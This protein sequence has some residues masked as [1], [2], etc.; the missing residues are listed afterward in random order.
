MHKLAEGGK[1]D[2]L[3]FM[4]ITFVLDCQE[5]KMKNNF[6]EFK[7]YFDLM[8]KFKPVYRDA[9]QKLEALQ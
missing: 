1:I 3:N 7:Q 5:D 8:E 2:C 9:R 4:P 6:I